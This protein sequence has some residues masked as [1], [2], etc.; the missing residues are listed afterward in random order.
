[1]SNNNNNKELRPSLGYRLFKRYVRFLHNRLLYRHMY[2]VNTE[3]V[4]PIGTPVLIVSNHQNCANDPLALLLS[5]E[6]DT[7]PYV[8]ARG[9]VFAWNPKLASFF[10][11][12]GMLPAFRLHTEGAES[13]GKNE[14][15]IRI[16]GG[17][18]LKGQ[19]LIMYPEGTHQDKR[20][21]GEFSFGYT[22][23]AFQT[24]EMNDF[25][26]DILILPSCNHY[27]SYFGLQEDFMVKFGT[28]ISLKPYYELYKT[29]PRTAQREVNKLVRA[30]IEGMM[31]NI[32][33]LD[34]Y[35][36]IDTIRNTYGVTYAS[37][38][39]RNPNYLPDKLAS[40]RDLFEAIEQ[41]KAADAETVQQIFD[42]ARALQQGLDQQRLDNDRFD[43]APSVIATCAKSLAQIALLPVWLLALWPNILCYNLPKL[44]LK[45]DKMFTNSLLLILNVLV[46]VPLFLLATI[47]VAGCC[48]GWWWQSV[49]WALLFPAIALFAW[50]DYKWMRRTVRDWRFLTHTRCAK[51]ETL[52]TL[53][54]RLYKN[55]NSVLN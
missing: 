33:D 31:L 23:M 2:A 45:T 50:Y 37:N 29:K 51:F 28:P 25:Q 42:D 36:A 44:F 22:R 5:L 14:E 24:A 16:S 11:W 12:I 46:F 3:A 26:T 32:T 41:A 30:Q 39:G 48:F 1:M 6:I 53:R 27:S 55:L 18:L 8:I 34:N 15:T 43:N 49:V 9:D 38:H 54:N 35:D 47:L 19:R 20:W 17:E 40:D 7:H 13:L 10:K 21:L 4:P 52:R